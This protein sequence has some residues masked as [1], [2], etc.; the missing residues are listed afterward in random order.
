MDEKLTNE[1][2]KYVL[3]RLKEVRAERKKYLGTEKYRGTEKYSQ[4]ARNLRA[5]ELAYNHLHNR[6]D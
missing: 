2:E 1:A 5:L 3:K 4:Y 6:E